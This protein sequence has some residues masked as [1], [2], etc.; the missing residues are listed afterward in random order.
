MPREH[1]FYNDLPCWCGRTPTFIGAPNAHNDKV[2]DYIR[3]YEDHWKKI[4]EH[5]NGTIN[6]DQLARELAD[7]SMYMRHL[8]EIY[9]Y[10]THG[11][12]SKPNTLPSA[13][14]EIIEELAGCEPHMVID[15][16]ECED[17]ENERKHESRYVTGDGTYSDNH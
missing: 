17:A 9:D 3:E 11:R 14:I 1:M 16:P 2:P 12:V 8:S 4:V 10:V 15:C 6:M 5:P 13:V 7:C